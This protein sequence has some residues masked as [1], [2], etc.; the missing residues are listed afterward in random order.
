MFLDLILGIIC[1]FTEIERYIF[2]YRKRIKQRTILKNDAEFF[3]YR[4]Q[5]FFR[6]VGYVKII[7][8]VKLAAEKVKEND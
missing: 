1:K 2:P 4:C 7:D 6:Q 3:P 8:A 5:L